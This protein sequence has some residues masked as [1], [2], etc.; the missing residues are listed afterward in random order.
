MIKSVKKILC[1]VIAI[2]VMVLSLSVSVFAA[3]SAVLHLNANTYSV[4]QQVSVR[5]TYNSGSTGIV[6]FNGTVT[7]DP[8]ILQ[9]VSGGTRC[10]GNTV[11]IYNELNGETSVQG[12]IVFNAVAA[13]SYNL[14]FDAD[15]S[16]GDSHIPARTGAKV[17]V[18]GAVAPSTPETSS[19]PTAQNSNN[20]NLASLTVTGGTLSPNFASNITNYTATVPFESEEV[21]VS[22][23]VADA[24][25]TVVGAGTF[26]VNVGNNKKT[27]TVRAAGGAKKTYTVN[28]VRLAQGEGV[29]QPE[30]TGENDPLNV[31]ADGDNKHIMQDISSMPMLEGFTAVSVPFGDVQVGAMTDEKKEYTVYYLT[32]PDGSDATLYYYD[33]NNKSFKRLPYIVFQNKTYILENPK[34]TY[35]EPEGWKQDVFNVCNTHVISFRSTNPL[36]QDIIVLYAYADGERG[37][38]RYDKENNSLQKSPDFVLGAERTEPVAKAK[39]IISRFANMT[40]MGKTVLILICFAGLCVIAIVVFA[41]LKLVR[42][43]EPVP[44][45]FTGYVDDDEDGEYFVYGEK[46]KATADTTPKDNDEF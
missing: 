35:S 13:G 44:A 8:N 4:G 3:A 6:I 7:F 10:Q 20:A 41:I 31:V 18:T 25:A 34:G 23:N 33:E 21:T 38:Y 16:D 12:T 45:N 40:A 32:N 36:M 46:Q 39:S 14:V 28:I 2:C 1:A 29:S 43:P 24:G 37:F 22:A 17:T 11:Q 30:I 5:Y 27:V 9:Y 26:K 19:Q 15:G 42:A